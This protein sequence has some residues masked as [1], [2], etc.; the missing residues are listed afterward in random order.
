MS[1]W[2]RLTV[3]L[4]PMLLGFVTWNKLPEQIPTHWNAQGV[5]DGYS[6]KLSAICFLPLFF[7]GIEL[8]VSFALASDPK[9]HNQDHFMYQLGLW[10]L[11]VMAVITM[12]ITYAAALGQKIPVNLIIMS[13]IGILFILLGNQM[14]KTRQNYTIGIKVPWTLNSEQNWNLTHRLAGPLWVIGGLVMIFLG[15]LGNGPFLIYVLLS[16][17][18]TL[19]I[20]PIVYS[21]Y[22]YKKGI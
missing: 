9:N 11:P 7:A 15:F 13:L 22:L 1:L 2:T 12:G 18:V 4:L 3:C 6:S 19:S 8:I 17:L 16:V 21:Y 20:I 14:P 5:V 10:V